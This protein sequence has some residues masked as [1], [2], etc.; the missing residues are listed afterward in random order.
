MRFIKKYS[1]KNLSIICEKL[2]GLYKD[3][4]QIT[5]DVNLLNEFPLRKDYK[6]SINLHS[7]NL[8]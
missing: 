6:N 5:K 3:G 7:K 4:L 1:Y 8:M 2:S